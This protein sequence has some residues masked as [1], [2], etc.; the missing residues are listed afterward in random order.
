MRNYFNKKCK[1]DELFRLKQNIRNLVKY[2]LK[3]KGVKKESK[4]IN[5]LG[6]SFEEF[7]NYL[8]SKFENWM[9]WE[10]Y[11]KYNGKPKFGWDIDHIIPM[12]S[13]KDEKTILALNQYTNL[14]PLCSYINRVT[15]KD[16]F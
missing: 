7:K 3:N 14:Q 15:K 11:G 12:S 13:G 6:C 1:T 8:E 4:T 5:I 16:K 10:N 9:T 2:S